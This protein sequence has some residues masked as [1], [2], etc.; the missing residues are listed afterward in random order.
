M[1]RINDLYEGAE[2]K[3]DA[4]GDLVLDQAYDGDS[5][6]VSD[7][8]PNKSAS[9]RKLA[10]AVEDGTLKIPFRQLCRAVHAAVIKREAPEA[11]K[12]LFSHR[13]ALWPLRGDKTKLRKLVDQANGESWSVRRIEQEVR[14][15]LGSPVRKPRRNRLGKALQVLSR[16]ESGFTTKEWDE[17]PAP[18][19]DRWLK[20][21]KEIPILEAIR[22]N[23][24][25]AQPKDGLES[26]TR[27]AA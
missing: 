9:F 21:C 27:A 8:N 2:T 14:K 24:E 18:D 15:A 26:Q 1:E 3:L 16:E 17:L 13:A 25:K 4:I 11:K 6:E 22:T 20:I 12:L 5:S 10:D 23:S 19:R 7:R